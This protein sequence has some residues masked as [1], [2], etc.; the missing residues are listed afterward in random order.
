MPE[1]KVYPADTP[2]KVTFFDREKYLDVE[3]QAPNE[4]MARLFARNCLARDGIPTHTVTLIK[5][6]RV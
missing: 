4:I 5:T 2:W 3:V 1:P 6:E